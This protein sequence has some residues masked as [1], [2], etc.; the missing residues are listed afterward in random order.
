MQGCNSTASIVKEALC[1]CM[2]PG[3]L[4]ILNFYYARAASANFCLAVL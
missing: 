1:S 2:F 3:V 4:A